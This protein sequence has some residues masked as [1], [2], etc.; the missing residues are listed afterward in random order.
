MWDAYAPLIKTGLV[1]VA[2]AVFS[3]MA[4]GLGY[5]AGFRAG[6]VNNHELVE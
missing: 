6:A 1:V 3:L 2:M 4:V 5:D